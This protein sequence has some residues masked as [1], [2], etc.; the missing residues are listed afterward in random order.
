MKYAII[1]LFLLIAPVSITMA[2]QQTGFSDPDDIQQLLDYRLPDWGYSNFVLDLYSRGDFSSRLNRRSEDEFER[3][4]RDATFLFNPSYELYRESED[5]ILDFRGD[6]TIDYR[7]DQNEATLDNQSSKSK[8]WEGRAGFD[9]ELQEYLSPNIYFLGAEDADFRYFSSSD[10]ERLNGS[11]SQDEDRFQ[12]IISSNTRVGIGIGRVRNVSPVIRALRLKE[13]YGVLANGNQLDNGE[14]EE[15]ADVFTRYDGYQQ[16]YDRPEKHFWQAMD[17]ASS[18]SF[19]DLQPFD[20]LYLTD[21]LD[22]SIGQRLEGWELAGGG[23]FNYSNSLNRFDT[24][25]QTPTFERSLSIGKNAGAFVDGRWFK[26]LSL[27]HQIGFTVVAGHTYPLDSDV[28]YKWDTTVRVEANWLWNVTDRF[29]MNTRLI[30]R[31]D[32]TKQKADEYFDGGRSWVND[33]VLSSSFTYFIE[34]RLAFNI[35]AR[36]NLSYFGET[37]SQEVFNRRV[38]RLSFNAGVQYYFS[39]N[40]Y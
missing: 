6:L 18:G 13:R 38:R 24:P 39:R 27:N 14:V 9:V 15:A 5:R 36:Y 35:N 33:S 12:R 20:M 40:L 23:I 10:E 34:N 22:E 7:G 31:Y 8:E 11:L 32:A 29:L 2:Q 3:T 19:S 4:G 25:F 1:A 30:N 28:Q 37:A 26:N 16:Q 17:E 21:V